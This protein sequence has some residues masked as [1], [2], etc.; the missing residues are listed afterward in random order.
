VPIIAV[1][2]A[3]CALAFL[4]LLACAQTSWR[5]RIQGSQLA[6]AFAIQ[7]FWATLIASSGFSNV[8]IPSLQVAS[9][10]ARSLA[11]LLVLVTALTPVLSR[12][13]PPSVVPTLWIV[14]SAVALAALLS[15]LVLQGEALAIL[16]VNV[17]LW[18]G[19]LGAIA[20]LVLV[21]QFARNTREDARWSLKYVWLGIGLVFTLDLAVWSLGLLGARLDGASWT[22]RGVVN[23]LVAPLLYISLGRIRAWSTAL[24][25]SAGA[26]FFNTTL[27]MA[28]GYVLL[29]AA[30]SYLIKANWA[31][32]G[33]LVE[34]VFVA[35]AVVLLAVAVFSDQ[36]RAWLRVTLAKRLRP[37][38]YDYRDVWLRL[39]RALTETSDVPL[40]D[41][42]TT[43]MASFVNSGGGAL[44]VRD[45]EG[46]YRR[47]GGPLE[48]PARL[49]SIPHDDFLEDLRRRDWIY[50][51]ADPRGEP[52]AGG[53]GGTATPFPQPPDWLTSDAR[54]WLVVPLVCNDTM[55]GF[56]VIA[57]PLAPT[58]LGWE[59]LDIL[60]AAGRQVA[61]YL[62]FEQA[63]TLLAEMHQFEALNRLS[64]FVMHDLRHLVAQLALVVDNAARHR[65]NPEFIDDAILTIE[66]S[67]G[68]MNTLMEVLRTGVVQ[69]PDRRLDLTEV[70]RE[71]QQRCRHRQPEVSVEADAG[72]V[73]VM[74]NR[75]RLMQALEHLVR[76]AQE[77]TPEVGSVTLRVRRGSHSAS[78]EI[79]DTGCGMDPEFIRTRL[80]KPF[81]T[82]KGQQGMGLGAYEAREIVRKLGGSL[83]VESRPQSGSRFLIEL[84]LAP[85]LNA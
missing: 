82:T 61:S 7:A 36:F 73:E 34:A 59:Q 60:R 1:T 70:G 63:A 51:L 80:F 32:S 16:L 79:A 85:V 30:A 57:R 48:L 37:Y 41:R 4:G 62:A 78:V 76:N 52:A 21:E 42:V 33:S 53:Q 69:E 55:A 35:A 54:A 3:L 71:I 5:E 19:L 40:H 45:A 72:P 14:G 29:M 74:A 10:V 67:V 20:G 23:L 12:S 75:E 28:G 22:A 9:E 64:G 38:R 58:R 15:P 77:A 49:S 56:A 31:A 65:S 27:V 43:A 13:L 44:W 50:D 24:F 83:K 39:T 8:E 47:A 81:D 25:K 26:F 84:P 66:S 68:R 18:G 2:Y 17:Q 6:P 46:A 11:W